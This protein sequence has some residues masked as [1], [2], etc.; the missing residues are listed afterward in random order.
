MPLAAAIEKGI[1]PK[2]CPY[3]AD[4][5]GYVGAQ[6]LSDSQYQQMKPSL[7][8]AIASQP[9]PAWANPHE[10]AV[11]LNGE[12]S[13]KKSGNYVKDLHKMPVAEEDNSDE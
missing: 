8:K 13:L 12:E 1:F 9:F 5:E 7:Q 6:V 2:E 4:M 3:V 11:F 10:Y